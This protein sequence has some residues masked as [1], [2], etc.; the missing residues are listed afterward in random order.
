MMAKG[1]EYLMGLGERGSDS[2][3]G[4]IRE[5]WN[6]ATSDAVKERANEHIKS[7]ARRL[8]VDAVPSIATM[9]G[10]APNRF[11]TLLFVG[12]EYKRF[13]FRWQL[14]PNNPIESENLR[15]IHNTLKMA[16]SPTIEHSVLWGYPAVLQCRFT[17][18]DS[19]LFH[20]KPA[21]I[22]SV[23]V[24]FTPLGRAA[25]YQGNPVL[26]EGGAPEGCIIEL[27]LLELEYWIEANGE[28]PM[29][30][31]RPRQ[32]VGFGNVNE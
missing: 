26:P 17:P 4:P 23:A 13:N 32:V 3:Y 15:V 22:T 2:W 14:S 28:T 16:A 21:V 1:T 31:Q 8:T 9:T 25:F 12:P 19:Q 10:L 20:F 29:M 6:D 18:N 27:Q 11:Q 24:N 30:K 5:F 7:V